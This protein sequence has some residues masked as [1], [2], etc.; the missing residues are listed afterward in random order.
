MAGTSPAMTMSIDS[1]PDQRP[2]RLAVTLHDRIRGHIRQRLDGQCRIESARR[3][4]IGAANH[5]QIRDVP[6]L[7]V[8]VHHRLRR[9]A[10]HADAA[11][12]VRAGRARAESGRPD[13]GGAHGAAGLG[14]LGTADLTPLGLAPP[15][16]LP[17]RALRTHAPTAKHPRTP[18][19]LPAT[20]AT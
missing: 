7:S 18:T 6:G 15:P 19:H 17:R 9:V 8:F 5:E 4:E 16:P 12:V 2:R 13:M 11:L 20:L 3:A 14:A 1:G 10:A